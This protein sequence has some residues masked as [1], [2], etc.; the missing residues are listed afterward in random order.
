M[1]IIELSKR[2]DL[3]DN[4][5]Q[6]FWSCWGKESNFDFYRDCI[7]NALNPKNDLPKFF[8]VLENEKIIAS[9]ALL[10]NDIISRQDL[11]PWFACLFVNETHRNQGIAGKLLNHAIIQTKQKG[12]KYLYLNSDLDNFYERKGW[13]IFSKGLKR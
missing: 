12:Y 10:V 3:L 1:K 9:Y 11:K 13:I 5:I 8:I 6:Y 4:A 7:E 2:P